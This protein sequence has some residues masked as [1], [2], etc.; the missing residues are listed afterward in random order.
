[1]AKIVITGIAE[2]D[3]KLR[4]LGPKVANK[5]VRQA[6]RKGDQ[7]F[8]AAIE[9]NAP[10]GETGDLAGS[11]KVR[12]GKRSRTGQSVEVGLDE[13]TF[14]GD[15]FYAGFQEYGT[16]D[17]EGDGF[18]HEA[19]DTKAD[20]VKRDIERAIRDGIEREAKG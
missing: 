17:M 4:T 13:A 10:Q 9:H 11:V 7:A 16:G 19:F 15:R 14:E 1:M 8:K 18:V 20:G 6:M 12:A 5:V 3:K 2:L